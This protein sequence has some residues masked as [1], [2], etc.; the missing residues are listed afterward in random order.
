MIKQMKLKLEQKRGL[1]DS[2]SDFDKPY[3][4]CLVEL[5]DIKLRVFDDY[6]RCGIEERIERFAVFK[7]ELSE[8]ERWQRLTPSKFGKVR[9]KMSE[10]IENMEEKVARIEADADLETDY[11]FAVTGK[12]LTL[13]AKK[14]VEECKSIKRDFERN[15]EKWKVHEKTEWRVINQ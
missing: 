2:E 1:P 6:A 3:P 15:W 5:A 12:Q 14:L 13:E 7:S 11:K 8:H 9:K 4:R 10:A